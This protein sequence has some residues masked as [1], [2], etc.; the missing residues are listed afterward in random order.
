MKRATGGRLASVPSGQQD[1]IQ[2]GSI[3]WRQYHD[4]L[5]SCPQFEHFHSGVPG[6]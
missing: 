5:R 1:E 2:R 3:A 6:L 4:L